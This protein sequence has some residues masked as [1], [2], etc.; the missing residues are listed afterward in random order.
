MIKVGNGDW[1]PKKIKQI[2]EEKDR[3]QCAKLAPAC[4]LYLSQ[5]DYPV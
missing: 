4:G 3:N 2:L 1:E 5:V